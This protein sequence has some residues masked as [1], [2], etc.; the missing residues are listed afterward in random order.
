MAGAVEVFG[1]GNLGGKEELC[2]V[3][4]WVGNGVEER[5]KRE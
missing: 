2:V 4:F 5:R 1:G 3:D